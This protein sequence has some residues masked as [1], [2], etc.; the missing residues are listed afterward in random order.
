MSAT[1][2]PAPSPPFPQNREFWVLMGYA[3]GLGVFGAFAGL[4]FI[5]VIGFGGRP[6]PGPVIQG[7]RARGRDEHLRPSHQKV[8]IRSRKIVRIRRA[9]GDRDV[10]TVLDEPA[11]LGIGDR[12]LIHPQ[13]GHLHLPQSGSSSG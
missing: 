6:P 11:E 8:R 9:F 12:V 7:H 13:V 3:V 4:V 1:S 10:P 2:E 5:G